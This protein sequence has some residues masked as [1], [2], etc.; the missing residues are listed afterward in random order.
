MSQ[1]VSKWL[2]RGYNPNIPYL[3]VG[4]KPFTNHLLASWD[5]QVDSRWLAAF[6]P[7]TVID[8]R[9]F[10][11]SKL[12]RF[13]LR[14]MGVFLGCCWWIRFPCKLCKCTQRDIEILV[15]VQFSPASQTT[16]KPMKTYGKMEKISMTQLVWISGVLNQQPFVQSNWSLGG[17]LGS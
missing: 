5:M 6:L 12:F 16:W 17:I 11:N 14:T 2:V 3:Q 15:M 7:S 4:Y 10:G 13:L 1:E 8:H 9:H